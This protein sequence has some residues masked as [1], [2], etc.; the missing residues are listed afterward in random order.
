M[1]KKEGKKRAEK[2][3]SQGEKEERESQGEG[4][5]REKG[6]SAS[7][8]RMRVLLC[9][10]KIRVALDHDRARWHLGACPELLPAGHS[11]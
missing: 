5:G 1:R 10:R 6:M 3:E 7:A 8:G 4:R 9:T 2:K 11:S